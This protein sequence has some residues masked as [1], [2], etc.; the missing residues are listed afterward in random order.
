MLTKARV[1]GYVVRRRRV[2]RKRDQTDT[3]YQ[4]K[5]AVDVRGIPGSHRDR[6]VAFILVHAY[7]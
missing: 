2:R 4:V 6:T 3:R 7:V 1:N 5:Q